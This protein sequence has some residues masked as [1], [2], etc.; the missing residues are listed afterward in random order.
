MAT[1]VEVA[2]SW[3][4]VQPA[5]QPENA[6]LVPV[7]VWYAQTIAI[8][9]SPEGDVSVLRLGKVRVVV[10]LACVRVITRPAATVGMVGKVMTPS[11]PNPLLLRGAPPQS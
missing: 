10:V 3:N 2:E 8:S 7:P 4:S 6:A 1:V 11:L 5:D 9:R